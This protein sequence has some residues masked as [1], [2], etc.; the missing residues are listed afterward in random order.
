[1]ALLS[2]ASLS[3]SS[4]VRLSSFVVLSMGMS[5]APLRAAYPLVM[6]SSITAFSVPANIV[7][8]PAVRPPVRLSSFSGFSIAFSPRLVCLTQLPSQSL[9]L[10]SEFFNFSLHVLGVRPKLA[11]LHPHP[12]DLESENFL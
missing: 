5:L 9:V 12:F 10:C 4:S 1:M 6:L 8:L 3:V 11:N 2:F 7:P